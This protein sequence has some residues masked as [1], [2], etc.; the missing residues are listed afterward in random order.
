MGMGLTPAKVPDPPPNDTVEL[1]G[2]TEPGKV[3]VLT[4][5]EKI[6]ARMAAMPAGYVSID[7]MLTTPGFAVTH[8]GG[9]LSWPEA[10]MRAYT[11]AVA[12][13][14]G[15]LEI[16]CQQTA[17]GIWVLNH[18]QTLQRVDPTAP[19]TP[20]IQTTWAQVQ[21]YR[22]QGEPSIRIE[23]VLDAYASSRVIVLDPTKYSATNW[24]ALA[25][26][27]PEGAKERVIWKFSI[28]AMWL[29]RQWVADGW[30]CWGYSYPEHVTSD[31]LKGWQELWT[32][33]GMSWDV[34]K[35]VWDKTLAFGK[36]VWGHI[37]PTGTAYTTAFGEGRHG[38]HGFR[39]CVFLSVLGLREMREGATSVGQNGP[40]LLSSRA[41]GP[42]YQ[43]V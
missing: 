21:T 31:Q 19:N 26:L 39:R 27:L 7:T 5:A 14:I 12:H 8:R 33:L 22:T 43:L 36:P 18:D 35:E 32:C 9:S 2:E 40:H 41:Q 23:Q 30:R 34:S 38:A 4:D 28:D 1:A 20:V 15:A 6:P 3:R 37:C 13:G 10:S 24:R 17:D 16:S 25:A 29:A 42:S 11:A